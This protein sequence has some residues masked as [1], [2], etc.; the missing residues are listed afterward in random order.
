MYAAAM[1]FDT[2]KYVKE[3]VKAGMPELQAEAVVRLVSESKDYDL[4]KLATKEQIVL[5]DQKI[6][7]FRNE[8]KADCNML[9]QK[10]E[11]S[12][13]KLEQKIESSKNEFKSEIKDLKTEMH[14]ME[15]RLLFKL[16]IGL[17]TLMI[18]IGTG[19][20]WYVQF[21]MGRH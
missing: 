4:S 15:Y 13:E 16:G 20:A 9:D 6:E 3:F 7:Y 19:L 11:S 17:G 10:I 12:V 21:L 5:L 14:Y 1:S 18:S 2:H 8:A